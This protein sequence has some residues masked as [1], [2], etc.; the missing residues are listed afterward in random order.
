MS[1][2]SC[3]GAKS[4]FTARLSSTLIS[5]NRFTN[6]VWHA[7]LALSETNGSRPKMACS[8]NVVPRSVVYHC[9]A[10]VAGG[11]RSAGGVVLIVCAARIFGIPL[12]DE[13]MTLVII[14]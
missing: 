10:S 6:S 1:T 14:K 7:F 3:S 4:P 2:A 13:Y 11:K 5:G 12:P 9:A 8:V